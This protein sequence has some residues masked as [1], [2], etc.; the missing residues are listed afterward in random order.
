MIQLTNTDKFKKHARKKKAVKY[1]KSPEELRLNSG[2][3]EMDMKLV[4]ECLYANI[5]DKDKKNK[6]EIEEE[7]ELTI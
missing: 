5:P 1:V 4:Y 6:I 7:N 2:A 3:S